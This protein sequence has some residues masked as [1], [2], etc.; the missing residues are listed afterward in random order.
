MCLNAEG[1]ILCKPGSCHMFTVRTKWI[2]LRKGAAWYAKQ[3][4]SCLNKGGCSLR[5]VHCSQKQ[6]TKAPLAGGVDTW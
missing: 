6:A 1:A 5:V 2:L 3:E 4:A